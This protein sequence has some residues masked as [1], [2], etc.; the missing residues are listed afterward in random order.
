MNHES[1]LLYSSCTAIGYPP[2]DARSYRR[3]ENPSKNKIK[4]NQREEAAHWR[5]D[6][7]ALCR[8]PVTTLRALRGGDV[9]PIDDISLSLSLSPLL[10]IS[11]LS[12]SLTPL[13]P[14]PPLP[15]L[16]PYV[17]GEARG[18]V[19]HTHP[20]SDSSAAAPTPTPT[21][22]P[23]PT[24]T[25]DGGRRTAHVRQRHQTRTRTRT[26]TGVLKI[27]EAKARLALCRAQRSGSSNE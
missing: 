16:R 9:Q 8:P 18:R 19:Q 14:L 23:A 21:P 3:D 13:T 25:A 24:A 10:S 15:P 4:K 22:T 6:G 26:R 2:H 12:P 1:Y 7:S 17:L 20:D 27:G 5:S 11:S